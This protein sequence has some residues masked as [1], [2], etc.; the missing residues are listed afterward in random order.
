M[1]NLILKNKQ[2]SILSSKSSVFLKKDLGSLIVKKNHSISDR[3]VQDRVVREVKMKDRYKDAIDRKKFYEKS[4]KK[5]SSLTNS[6]DRSA[7]VIL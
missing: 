3:I 7:D 1:P 4:W 5:L 6:R 2:E